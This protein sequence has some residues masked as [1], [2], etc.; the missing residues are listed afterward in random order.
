MEDLKSHLKD[1]SEIRTLMERSTKFLSLSG[2]SGVSAGICA[3]VGAGVAWNWL[4]ARGWHADEAF[5][6]GTYLYALRGLEWDFVQFFF[7]DAGLTLVLALATAMFFSLRMARK[8]GLPIWN[9]TALNLGINMA[10][11]LVAGGLLCLIQLYHGVFGWIASTTL[12][13][14]GMA[15]LNASKYTLPEIRWLGVSEIAL[16]LACAFLPGYGLHFWAI[17]FGL[18]HIVYGIVMYMR[19]ER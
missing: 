14:Y 13:F 10:I 11:P 4:T 3:L 8:K 9:K 5:S 18:L 17:G 19:Y 6:A 7:L 12:L 2:L 1:I 15:L 16:G